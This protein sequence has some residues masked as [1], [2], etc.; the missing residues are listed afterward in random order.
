MFTTDESNTKDD[1]SANIK[2]PEP[3]LNVANVDIEENRRSWVDVR[4]TSFANA[5]RLNNSIEL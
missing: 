3:R 2:Y 5:E 1:E 4:R